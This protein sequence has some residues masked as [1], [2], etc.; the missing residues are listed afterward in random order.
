MATLL[1][2]FVFFLVVYSAA[3]IGTDQCSLSLTCGGDTNVI[4]GKDIYSSAYKVKYKL[5]K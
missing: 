5:R 4:E 3:A 1:I 2:Q